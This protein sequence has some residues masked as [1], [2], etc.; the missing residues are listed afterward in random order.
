MTLAPEHQ[1]ADDNDRKV[2]LFS[3][4]NT[5]V[6]YGGSPAPDRHPGDLSPIAPAVEIKPGVNIMTPAQ[7]D[8]LGDDDNFRR[9]MDGGFIVELADDF[10][11]APDMNVSVSPPTSVPAASGGQ[12]DSGGLTVPESGANAIG[13]ANKTA[14]RPARLADEDDVAYTARV[15]A[16]NRERRA[17]LKNEKPAAYAARM[18]ALDAEDGENA[19]VDFLAS[20]NGLSDEDKTA[21]YESLS[22]EEKGWVNTDKAKA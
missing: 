1:R 3:N 13:G 22:D 21:M 6:A 11:P 20:Y 5:V 12:N 9:H 18:A 2:R 19:R 16:W 8:A 15:D 4:I 7:A 14:A 10:E 17:K